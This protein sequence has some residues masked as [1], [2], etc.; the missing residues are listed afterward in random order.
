SGKTKCQLAFRILED[1]RGTLRLR[2]T[3]TVWSLVFL[4]RRLPMVHVSIARLFGPKRMERRCWTRSRATSA[5]RPLALTTTELLSDCR[6]HL[7][8]CCAQW[9]GRM[10][11]LK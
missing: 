3:T 5:A 2:S 9:S 6:E 1:M 10:Q 4:Y 7:E 8:L 11:M